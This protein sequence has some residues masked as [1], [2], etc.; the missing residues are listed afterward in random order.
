MKKRL[1]AVFP[2]LVLLVVVACSKKMGEKDYYD[3]ANQYMAQ[4]KWKLAEENF[5]KILQEYPN[6]VYSSKAMFMVGF[7]N[8]NYLN[9]F[10]KARKYYSEFLEKYPSHD[11]ADDA[12]YELE[13]LGKDIDDLP[14][15]KGETTSETEGGGGQTTQN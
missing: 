2:L 10:E 3:L 12:K 6:G 15:L 5:E 11:L 7:I 1:L 13:N 9:N 8:A 14:F 4:E